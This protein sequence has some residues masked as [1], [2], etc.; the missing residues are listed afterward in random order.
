MGAHEI[1]KP[2]HSFLASAH[3]PRRWARLKS[4]TG[5]DGRQRLVKRKKKAKHLLADEEVFLSTSGRSQFQEDLEDV[6]REKRSCQALN[7]LNNVHERTCF[8][9]DI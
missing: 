6:G 1:S 3:T 7:N 9:V 4:K 5:H 8:V 2:H